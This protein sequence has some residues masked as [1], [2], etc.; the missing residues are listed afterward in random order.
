M[1]ITIRQAKP[2]RSD[3]DAFA[4]G[5]DEATEGLFA[6]MF[7]KRAHSIVAEASLQPGH[8]LSLEHVR[9]AEVDGRI[10]GVCSGF[11]QDE[12]SPSDRVLTRAAGWRALRALP[13]DVALRPLTRILNWHDPGDWYLQALAVT[14]ELRGHGIGTVLL[15]DA[16]DRARTK[17]YSWLTLDVDSRNVKAQHLYEAKGMAVVATSKPARLL[18]GIQINRMVMDLEEQ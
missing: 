11:G 15:D 17:G 9:V 8:D 18:G 2:V 6:A 13:V 16:V 7:G 5:L 10:A 1:A 12:H 3:A 14:P 4:T